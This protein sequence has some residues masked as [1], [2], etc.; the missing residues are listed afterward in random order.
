LINWGTPLTS[1]SLNSERLALLSNLSDLE[2]L[3]LPLDLVLPRPL[4]S[5]R[6]LERCR[7][8]DRLRSRRRERDRLRS[9]RRER[10]LVVRR[11]LERERDDSLPDVSPAI[12]NT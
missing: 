10:D 8:R 1:S 4:D 2:R 3:R 5:E 6:D 7:E 12:L 11:D 9:R